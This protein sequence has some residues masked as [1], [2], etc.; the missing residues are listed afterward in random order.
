MD[1]EGRDV[2]R[3]FDKGRKMVCQGF[4]GN[5]H[6]SHEMKPVPLKYEKAWECEVCQRTIFQP[7][8]ERC[9]K[10]T[11]GSVLPY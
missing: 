7:E 6:P 4:Y 3:E 1:G 8:G 10:D 2:V 9:A 5:Y 11:A